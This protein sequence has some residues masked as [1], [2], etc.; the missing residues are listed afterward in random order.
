MNALR[1]VFSISMAG[2]L[3]YHRSVKMQPTALVVYHAVP[4]HFL[5]DPIPIRGLVS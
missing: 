1:E 3:A 4:D 2:A 5:L